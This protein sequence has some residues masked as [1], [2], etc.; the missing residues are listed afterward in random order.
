MPQLREVLRDPKAFDPSHALFADK[1]ALGLDSDCLILDAD[2][3][4]EGEDDPAEAREAGYDYVLM[5]D[6][7]NGI[8]TNLL[9]QVDQPSDDL[10]FE[11]FRFYLARDAYIAL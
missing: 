10:R 7:V 3:L 11:S 5:M 8:I 9:A 4:E 1:S 6:D 2:D